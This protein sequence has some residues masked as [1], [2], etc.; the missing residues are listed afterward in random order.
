MT[1]NAILWLNLLDKGSRGLIGCELVLNT[2]G[3]IQTC[4]STTSSFSQ[5]FIL[6]CP[7]LLQLLRTVNELICISLRD[8]FPHVRFL[9]KVLIS[10]LVG[11]VYGVFLAIE[12]QMCALHEVGR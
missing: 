4:W 7:H 6:L 3:Y 1:G 8:N 5:D 11:K 2:T 9:H 10:L 12:V